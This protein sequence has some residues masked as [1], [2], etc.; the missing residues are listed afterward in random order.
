MNR[1]SARI[2][3]NGELGPPADHL[4][5]LVSLDQR[6]IVDVGLGI[7]KLRQPLALDETVHTDAAGI[8]WR[9]IASDRPDAD[10]TIQYKESGTAEW[11]T[12]CIFRDVPREMSYFE[13]TCEYFALSPESGFR[14]DPVAILATDRG[15]T[16]LSPTTLTHSVDGELQERSI[17]EE[18][19]YDL[20]EHKFGVNWVSNETSLDTT[21]MDE[22]VH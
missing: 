14:D 21:E 16:K 2:E 20:L 4:T 18:E 9:I 12:R 11:E 3:S 15:H 19:W 10:Y 22:K 1:L 17:N 7:P 8:K 5:L 13:A 6:Y